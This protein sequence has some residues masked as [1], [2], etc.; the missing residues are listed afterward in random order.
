MHNKMHVTL[1]INA[2]KNTTDGIIRKI[3]EKKKKH[4]DILIKTLK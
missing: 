1:I 2:F 3:K 4:S